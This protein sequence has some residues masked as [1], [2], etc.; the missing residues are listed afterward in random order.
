[1]VSA[2]SQLKSGL[3]CGGL[4]MKGMKRWSLM[5]F[6]SN[7]VNLTQKKCKR[8]KRQWWPVWPAAMFWGRCAA[9]P[10]RRWQSNAWSAEAGVGLSA[11]HLKGG[12]KV[13]AKM[14]KLRGIIGL[15]LHFLQLHVFSSSWDCLCM[16]AM[17]IRV[18]WQLRQRAV[19]FE[20]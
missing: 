18:Q 11:T 3:P 14:E 2:A 13:K 12:W 17:M 9:A 16:S 8:R 4:C 6:Q 1:M 20:Y 10:G 7:T 15:I 19:T 5:T